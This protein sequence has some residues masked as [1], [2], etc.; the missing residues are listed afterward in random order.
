MSPQ[1]AANVVLPGTSRKVLEALTAENTNLRAALENLSNRYGDG[2]DLA[3]ENSH[4]HGIIMTL[5]DERDDK[6]MEVEELKRLLTAIE[7]EDMEALKEQNTCLTEK[8]TS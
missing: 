4:L 1:E 6:T 8:A 2:V 3:M 5:R 7:K